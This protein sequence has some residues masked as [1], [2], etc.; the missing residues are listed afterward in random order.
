M[1]TSKFLQK[2]IP[3]VVLILLQKI[4]AGQVQIK[5][6]VY[7]RSAHYG[8]RGVS[9]TGTSGVGTITDSLGC[10]SIKLAS[11]DSISFSYLG[12]ATQKFPVKDI[13]LNQSFDISLQVA[14]ELLPAVVVRQNN[15]RQDSLENRNEYRKV[16]D[17]EPDYLSGQGSGFGVGI[18][19]SALLSGKKIRRMEALKRRLEQEERDKYI[20]HRFTKALVKKVTGLKSPALD[21]FVL[22]YRPSYETLLSFE[23]Q[24]EYYKYIKDQ[25]IFFSDIWKK[26]HPDQPKD[27]IN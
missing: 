12:K 2:I 22:H 19:L 15:Y 25:A 23:N 20:D 26:E 10:Y 8:L 11:V 18:S 16:F 17:Y 14:V 7:D 3:F 4:V 6:I 5:G 24:Y 13:P 21:T 27:G 9:V 1:A